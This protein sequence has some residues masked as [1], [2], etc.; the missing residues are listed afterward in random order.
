MHVRRESAAATHDL[1]VS[2]L[3][4]GTV[5]FLFTDIEASTALLGELGAEE[6]GRRRSRRRGRH[7]ASWVCPCAWGF[8]PVRR[9]SRQRGTSALVSRTVRDLVAGSDV[10][11]EDRG[12]HQLK[13]VEEPWQLFAVAES[14]S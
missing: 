1:L 13:G 4:A 8:I 11:L 10:Q 14:V 6:Y 12:T 7:R 9:W 3:P 2:D 5:T